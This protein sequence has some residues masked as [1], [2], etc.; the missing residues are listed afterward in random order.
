RVELAVGGD[1]LDALPLEE[2]RER[3]VDEAHALLELRLLVLFGRVQRALE[4]VEDRKELLQQ[5]LV[6]ERDVLG[7]LTRGALLVVVEVGGEAQETVVRLLLLLRLLLDV[8]VSHWSRL[9]TRRP[10]RPRRR[11]SP[12]RCRPRTAEPA[13]SPGR[14]PPRRACARPPAATRPSRGCPRGRRPRA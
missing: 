10:R 4:V 7:A 1:L 6:R 9:R 12:T 2:R 5:A 14:R 3:A 11:R 8:L 13:R